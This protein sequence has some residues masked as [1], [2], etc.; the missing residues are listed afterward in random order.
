MAALDTS[1]F[2]LPDH[3]NLSYEATLAEPD[4][5]KDG[6]LGRAMKPVSKCL[7]STSDSLQVIFYYILSVTFGAILAVVWGIIFGVINFVTIWL[8]HPF[9]KIFLTVYRCFYVCSRASTRMCCDPFFESASIMYTR[10]RGGFH[11]TLD[12]KAEAGGEKSDLTEVNVMS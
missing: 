3:V 5:Y 1:M 7:E 6:P 11:V 9:I 2:E 4:Y 10:I 12:K 8:A